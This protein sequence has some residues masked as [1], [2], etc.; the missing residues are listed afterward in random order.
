M[1]MAWMAMLILVAGGAWA[2]TPRPTATP[3]AGQP[4]AVPGVPRPAATPTPRAT[5]RPTPTPRATVR[6]TPTPRATVR[7]TPTPRATVRP[8]P[9]ATPRATATPAPRATATPVPQ[10]TA[11]AAPTPQP[12]RT[13][14]QVVEV[15]KVAIEL[16][17]LGVLRTRS[18][19][20]VPPLPGPV[21][22]WQPSLT[23]VFRMTMPAGWELV[24]IDKALLTQ[25]TDH[26]GK[27]LVSGDTQGQAVEVTPG[28]AAVQFKVDL[29][30]RESERLSAV[31]G[32]F[33]V[34]VG[35]GSLLRVSDARRYL[36]QPM[37]DN[38]HYPGVNLS[39]AAVGKD[40]LT[41]TTVG[42]TELVGPLVFRSGGNVLEPYAIETVQ[43]GQSP[44]GTPSTIVRY[45]FVEL[46]EKFDIDLKYYSLRR[47]A[48]FTY[49]QANVP[50]P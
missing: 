23:L 4:P 26:Q 40:M 39:L 29:P 3:R 21:E 45:L 47:Q 27:A 9:T 10:A 49:D 12:A 33:A 34:T 24:T 38:N 20:E 14:E 7:A 37:L 30:G 11:T 17:R 1:K 28:G 25:V 8:T 35:Q 18:F 32:G 48:I 5:V 42:K 19:G 43:T 15:P 46:P 2:Q 31:V 36:K 44:E 50:L 6:P 22:L 41:V 13:P 16:E